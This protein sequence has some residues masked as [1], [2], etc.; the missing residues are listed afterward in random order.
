M[1][2]PFWM[3]RGD[4][5][6]LDSFAGVHPCVGLSSNV[7]SWCD[8]ALIEQH[9]VED[10]EDSIGV[11]LEVEEDRQPFYKMN[12]DELRT[13]VFIPLLTKCSTG[14]TGPGALRDQAT[15]SGAANGFQRS[16]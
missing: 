15:K 11:L 2:D 6:L 1:Y 16:T 4:S 13:I 12:V 7:E 8:D 3:A 5:V 10:I 9:R 14:R